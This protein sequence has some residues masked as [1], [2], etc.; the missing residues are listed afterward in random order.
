MCLINV[1]SGNPFSPGTE[2]DHQPLGPAKSLRLK[3]KFIQIHCSGVTVL[4]SWHDT[5][6][7]LLRIVSS[8]QP[9]MMH[10]TIY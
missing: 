4:F 9:E 2:G 1:M 5:V 8:K 3:M 6:N 7:K 10:H